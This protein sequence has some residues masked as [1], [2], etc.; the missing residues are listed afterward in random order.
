MPLGALPDALLLHVA[1]QLMD[2]SLPDCVSLCS[3]VSKALSTTLAPA[4]QDASSRQLFWVSALTHGYKICESKSMLTLVGMPNSDMLCAA[5][6][7]LPASGIWRWTLQSYSVNSKFLFGVCDAECNSGWGLDKSA[8]SSFRWQ[9]NPDGSASLRPLAKMASLGMGISDSS[10]KFGCEFDCQ[11]GTLKLTSMKHWEGAWID[12][13]TLMVMNVPIGVRV[14]PWA[15][16]Y[17][18]RGDRVRLDERWLTR[19]YKPVVGRLCPE[20]KPYFATD[21]R[22]YQHGHAAV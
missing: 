19:A 18:R 13:M 11:K 6:T 8:G 16:I 22:A 9:R 12:T 4:L 1:D 5:G 17:A 20:S 10:A 21:T 7:L 15:R 14:R 3:R 2:T